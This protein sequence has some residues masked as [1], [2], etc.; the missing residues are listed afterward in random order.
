MSQQCVIP[1]AFKFAADG[2][3]L[4]GTIP[5]AECSRLADMTASAEGR[6]AYVLGSSQGVDGKWQLELNVSG[7]LQLVCQRCLSEM[8]WPFELSST[9]LLVKPGEEIP[10]EELEDETRD[11]IEVHPDLEVKQ[12]VEDEILLAVP[13]VPRHEQCEIPQPV[14]G[15]TK[16]SPFAVLSGLK[17][18]GSV[19]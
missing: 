19:Q 3:R 14:G 11:A 17:K 7:S 13:I 18:P 8:Q 10:E 9:L 16:K 4:D 12:L 2:R 1:D 6:V 15:V 5:V